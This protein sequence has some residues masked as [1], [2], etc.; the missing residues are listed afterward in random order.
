M[1]M[2][3]GDGLHVVV[4]TG[5]LGLAIVRR[6]VR[7]GERVRAVNRSGQ[8]ELPKRVEL[9]AADA[10]EGSSLAQALAGGTILYHCASTP[11][12]TWPKT[13]PPIMAAVIQAAAEAGARI[14]Y[15]D[16]LYAYGPVAGPLTEGLPY[17]P[18]GANGRTRAELA[19]APMEAH[20][21]GLVRAT[22]GRASDFFGPHVFVSQAGERLFGAAV[23]GK[24]ASVLG[25]PDAAHTYTFID[26]FASALVTLGV[27]EEALG[28]VWHVPSAQTLSTREFVRLVFAELGREPRLRVMPRALLALLAIVNPTLRAVREVAYQLEQ[29]FVLD[30]SKFAG[31]FGA[32]PT[33][34][35]EAIRDTVGWYRTRSEPGNPSEDLAP[36]GS[37]PPH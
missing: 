20:G 27:R 15:G 8:A 31:A 5:P 28:E 18:R 25:N 2:S 9:V 16:N 21:N 7:N 11:Y 37:T 13:L 10:S 36:P 1:V 6:L 17:R 33:L 34:H 30:H 12:H 14:V 29:P 4:G 24:P 35:A 3:S 26:D 19:T 22:I 32:H 23:A